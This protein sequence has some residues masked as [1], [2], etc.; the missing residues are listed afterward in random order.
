MITHPRTC[1]SDIQLLRERATALLSTA[2]FWPVQEATECLHS[3]FTVRLRNGFTV[4]VST[5]VG[6]RGSLFVVTRITGGPARAFPFE[7]F[8][9]DDLFG[10]SVGLPA[11]AVLEVLAR[12]SVS[13]RVVRA[14]PDVTGSRIPALS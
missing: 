12:Y 4:C 5:D 1:P 9:E 3:E 7:Q 2:R 14:T 6:R 13:P 8:F 10:V 11:A